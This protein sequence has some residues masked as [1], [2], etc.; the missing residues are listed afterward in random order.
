M[1]EHRVGTHRLSLSKYYHIASRTSI[2]FIHLP[3]MNQGSHPSTTL[4]NTWYY[5]EVL[6]ISLYPFQRGP[7]R[8][9]TL[10]SKDPSNLSWKTVNINVFVLFLPGLAS[11]TGMKVLFIIPYPVLTNGTGNLKPSFIIL[12]TQLA[13][14][15]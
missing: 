2:P 10:L 11:L 15:N 1:L 5:P 13:F 7:S 3:A 8:L 6:V 14:Q 12:R 9:L 4:I